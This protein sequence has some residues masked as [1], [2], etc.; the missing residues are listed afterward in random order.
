MAEVSYPY[1]ESNASG[2]TPA[3]SEAQWQAMAAMWGGD[4]VDF[5]LTSD[6]Y[7]A[8]SLPFSATVINGRSV[9]LTPGRAIVG[10]F[11]YQLTANLTV[12]IEANPTTK[13]RKDTI[14]IRTDIPTGSTNV[15]VV[16]GQP[17]NSPVAPQP[18]RSAGQQW[19][20]VL[21]EINVPA[22]NGTIQPSNR[23]PFDM[24]PRVGA[25]WNAQATADF[26]P[27]GT[28]VYDLDSNGGDSQ[29]E[30]FV[31]RDG[32]VVAR[33]FGKSRTYTPSLMNVSS[34]PSSGVSYKGRWRYTA[35]NMVFFS[36]IVDNTSST[37]IK[38]I[39][40]SALGF[41]LPQAACGQTGQVISGHLRNPEKK[42]GLPN[43]C[44]VQGLCWQGQGASYATL[45]VPS[46]S[47][48]K[49]GLDLLT[50]IPGKSQLYITATYEANVFSE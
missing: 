7:A 23:M 14:V 48:L 17:S 6:S 35:P 43:F 18:Q 1:A 46:D 25:P 29:H 37:D 3:I 19:E 11:Y 26:L 10:G 4:R 8:N 15:K 22:L 38:S 39:S 42:G 49:E 50:V 45:F 34:Q 33:H 20:M 12:T 21:Y 2:G 31:G 40:G 30:S 32:Y 9:E 24:G 36:A 5:R 27:V 44:S 13:A 41:V 28:F 47:T 16:K